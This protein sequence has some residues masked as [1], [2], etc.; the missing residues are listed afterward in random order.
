MIGSVIDDQRSQPSVVYRH[1][2]FAPGATVPCAPVIGA[3]PGEVIYSSPAP[4]Q[5][6]YVDAAPQRVV[7]VNPAPVV[8]AR[9][10]VYISGGWNSRAYYGHHHRSYRHR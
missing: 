6:V 3:A 1:S 2:G 5:V 10:V 7:Y 9:P 4:G 8:V